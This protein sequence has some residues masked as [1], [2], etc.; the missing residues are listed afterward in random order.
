M[1][2]QGTEPRSSVS[3]TSTLNHWAISAAPLFLFYG[4][5]YFAFLYIW[6]PNACSTYGGQK[7]AV[8]HLELEL[9]VIVS[10]PPCGC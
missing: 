6:A 7:R 1:W 5:G 9:G 3:A 8:Y 10:E 4:Y 2:M